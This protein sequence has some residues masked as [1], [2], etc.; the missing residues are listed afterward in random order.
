MLKKLLKYDLR[1]TFKYWWLAAVSSLGLSLLCGLAIRIL[2]DSELG[3]NAFFAIFSVLIVILTVIGVSAFMVSA[4]VFIFIRYY[5]NF[6]SD[7]GY[8]TFTL[9]V[10][11]Y[12][13]LNSKIISSILISFATISVVA[14]D[15]FSLLFVSFG[16]EIFTA[17]F[18]GYA[19]QFLGLMISGSF[20][21]LGS[22]AVVYVLE[23]IVLILAFV[24]FSTILVFAAIT[25]AAMITKKNKVIAAIGIYYGATSVTSVVAQIV[26]T[27]GLIGSNGWL[28]L[29]PSDALA[30]FGAL[31]LLIITALICAAAVALYMFVYWM[32][33]RKLNLA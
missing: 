16:F 3:N 22:L 4:E 23:I 20:E 9:P 14:I 12:Q 24:M 32:L 13:L 33:D 17:E 26:F 8:L 29:I 31:V 2:N 6:F 25:F 18:W 30:G 1:A 5:Q 7:E 15:V 11:R 21:Q 28:T 10:K 27:V 19:L